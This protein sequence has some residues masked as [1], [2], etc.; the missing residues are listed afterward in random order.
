MKTMFLG[1]KEVLTIFYF[2]ACLTKSIF[3]KKN[4]SI[5]YMDMFAYM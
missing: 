2:L 4:Q 1:L 5:K 3:V